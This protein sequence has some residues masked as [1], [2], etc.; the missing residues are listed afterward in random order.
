MLVECSG[1][2][3]W[4]CVL[5]ELD[6]FTRLEKSRCGILTGNQRVHKKI[7]ENEPRENDLKCTLFFKSCFFHQELFFSF[8]T[9]IFIF[10]LNRSA[11]RNRQRPNHPKLCLPALPRLQWATR[12]NFESSI[13]KNQFWRAQAERPA[14]C[15]KCAW[16][17]SNLRSTNLLF[18][19]AMVFYHQFFI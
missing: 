5:A 7:Q 6:S 18:Y 15:E 8:L 1:Y 16:R 17:Y 12:L 11:F 19:T 14:K 10:F 2:S 3:E 9:H 4:S 13:T